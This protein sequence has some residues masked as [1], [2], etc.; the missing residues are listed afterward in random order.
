MRRKVAAKKPGIRKIPA[1]QKNKG[2]IR[3]AEGEEMRRKVA[4]KKPETRKM[5]A[6]EKDKE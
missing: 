5:P 4:A 3:R 1:G 6:G 2:R